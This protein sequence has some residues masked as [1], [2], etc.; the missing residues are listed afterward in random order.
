MEA[1]ENALQPMF[2]NASKEK[3]HREQI[4]RNFH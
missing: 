4:F 1:A 2:L 3:N